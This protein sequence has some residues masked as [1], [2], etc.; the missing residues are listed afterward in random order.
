[1]VQLYSIW[2]GSLRL[3]AQPLQ[4]KEH[5]KFEFDSSLKCFRMSFIQMCIQTNIA[6]F[7]TDAINSTR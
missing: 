5:I 3:C 7:L 2:T 1:M 4:L 6:L